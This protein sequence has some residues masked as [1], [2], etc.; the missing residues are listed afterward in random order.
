MSNVM[1][2]HNLEIMFGALGTTQPPEIDT[3]TPSTVDHLEAFFANYPKF[4]YRP[5]NTATDEYR[6]LCRLMSGDHGFDRDKAWM[7]LRDAIVL[8]FNK[9]YGTDENDLGSWQALC[10]VLGI[11]PVPT[12]LQE[13][14]KMVKAT[15]VNLVD[16]VHVPNSNKRIMLFSSEEALSHYTREN[17]KFF[18]LESAHAGSLLKHL[19]RQINAPR[20][21]RERQ[22]GG[23][24]RG[25]P[26]GSR[27]GQRMQRESSQGQ[28]GSSGTH[29][30]AQG[31][32][33]V[34]R[35]M[36]VQ[37]GSLST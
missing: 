15:H 1:S 32:S 30:V 6:R 34:R 26:G 23:T 4:E 33:R 11:A 20:T 10:R 31:N 5:I 12:T 21:E 25:S 27:G 7:D 18:P 24:Q 37:R 36:R 3:T 16:L 22:R 19:L 9:I 17:G 28:R 14:R 8:E 29:R 35:G 2:V 13:C